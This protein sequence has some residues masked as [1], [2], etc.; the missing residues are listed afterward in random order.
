MKKKLAQYASNV[1]SASSIVFLFVLKG[2]IGSPE[3]PQEL[4]KK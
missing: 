3:V 1:L 2:A 4:L